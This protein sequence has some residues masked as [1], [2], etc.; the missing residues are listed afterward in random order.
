MIYPGKTESCEHDFYNPSEGKLFGEMAKS[1]KARSL[2]RRRGMVSSGRRYTQEKNPENF[3]IVE[4]ANF[5]RRS[6]KGESFKVTITIP[7]NTQKE[8]K[9]KLYEIT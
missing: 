7:Y 2:I 1:R 3:V 5:M 6:E 4:F 8:K 9:F